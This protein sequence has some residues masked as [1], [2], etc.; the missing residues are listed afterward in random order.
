[1][2]AVRIVRG[3]PSEFRSVRRRQNLLPILA[4]MLFCACQSASYGAADGTAPPSQPAPPPF[5]VR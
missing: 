3:S 5:S 1:M 2:H 4:A